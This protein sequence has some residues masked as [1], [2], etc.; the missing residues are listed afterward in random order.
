[1]LA[2]GVAIYLYF[3][4]A[5]HHVTLVTGPPP[6]APAVRVLPEEP[7]AAPKPAPTLR[8]HFAARMQQDQVNYN[9]QQLREVES[10]YQVANK[11]WQSPEAKESLKTL[12]ETYGKAD[13]TGCAVLYLGQ[14]SS[15]DEK[16]TYLKR[17]M[18]EFGDCW[19]GDGVQVGAYARFVLAGY[20]RQVSRHDEAEKLYADLRN[21]YPDAVDHKGRLLLDS[22]P[23]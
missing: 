2:T 11:Q 3:Q 14:M 19:Y 13:R 22:I 1:M 10:L 18:E 8:E 12:I 9:R 17:A 20:Y 7:V 16:V 21:N 6:P 4:S 23:K 5:N 15:G